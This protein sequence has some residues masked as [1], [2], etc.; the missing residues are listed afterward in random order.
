[1]WNIHEVFHAK[2]KI[3]NNFLFFFPISI[4]MNLNVQV[5]GLD[6]LSFEIFEEWRYI[7]CSQK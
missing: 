1:M 5:N 4:S 6:N 2:P 3:I 7:E